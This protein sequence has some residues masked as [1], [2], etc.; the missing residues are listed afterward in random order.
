V[1]KILI[2]KWVLTIV[3]LA[4]G[5]A[6][7]PGVSARANVVHLVL[8]HAKQG[9]QLDALQALITMFQGTHP[10]ITIEPVYYANGTLQD[11]F[12]KSSTD[13]RPDMIL[14]G[15]DAVGLWASA[16]LIGDIGASIPDGLKAQVSPM[17]WELF[18]YNDGL[19]AVPYHAQTLAFFY[20]KTLV[21]SAPA[22]WADLLSSAQQ[23]HSNHA[24]VMGLAF[25]NGFFQ[26]A[27][28]LFALGGQLIDSDGNATFGDGSDGAA[29][30]DAYLQ[31]QQ[32]MNKLGQDATS[33]VI[34]DASSP[35]PG[36][37]DGTVAMLYDG[38][39]NLAQY[40]TDLGDKLGVSTMPALDN[41]KAPAPFAQG[42]AF[43]LS[44]SA[45]T[46]D[47]KMQAFIEWGK[48]VT[49]V[50]IQATA[51]K[52]GSFL[53]VN[54]A[55]KLDDPNLKVFADQFALGTPF[56]DRPETWWFWGEMDDA[57]TAVETGSK[58]PDQARHDAYANIQKEIDAMHGVT[59]ES[60]SPSQNATPE[61][62]TSP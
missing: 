23:V 45:S 8:W 29:A 1:R 15:S 46:D 56:P 14:A 6:P 28:F 50:S 16:G 13:Q 53:P 26:S 61:A 57:I 49:S 30:M 10:S 47:S 52:Q 37:E 44:A 40:E 35:N 60:T 27:G 54:P 59:P 7:I 11:T 22:T 33:G 51:L 5:V 34:V 62:T 48:Y 20:N 55:V 42:E 2:R 4:L 43:S 9:A 24:K 21:P 17:A 41:G 12:A 3:F 58:S 19:Y 39:W 32:D 18:N 25:Q 31:F 38:L 36:F